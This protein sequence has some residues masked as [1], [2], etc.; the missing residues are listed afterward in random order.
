MAKFWTSQGVFS[1][2]LIIKQC[3][4]PTGTGG[5]YR[6]NKRNARK[7]IAEAKATAPIG[8]MLNHLPD[9]YWWRAPYSPGCYKNG[10]DFIN[11]GGGK[12]HH[13]I[14]IIF[15]RCEH[16]YWV[17][18]GRRRSFG[19]AWFV[20]TQD[21]WVPGVELFTWAKLGGDA[22]QAPYGTAGWK[23]KRTLY[24]AAKRVYARGGLKR[25]VGKPISG[26]ARRFS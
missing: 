2:Q 16:A 26:L 23:G 8:D 14:S 17:E 19:A 20:P 10:F 22:V 18:E 12:R 3:H 6:W 11:R 13:N 4:S 1:D 24:P 9:P 15:N 5:V 21:A 25:L 7:V